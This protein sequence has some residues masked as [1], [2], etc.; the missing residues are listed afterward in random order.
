MQAWNAAS[1]W[2]ITLWRCGEPALVQFRSGAASLCV[3]GKISSH[4]YLS[5]AHYHYWCFCYYHCKT[6]YHTILYLYVS[7]GE[8]DILVMCANGYNEFVVLLLSCSRCMKSNF[9]FEINKLFWLTQELLQPSLQQEKQIRQSLASSWSYKPAG[10]ALGLDLVFSSRWAAAL[11]PTG[12]F[13]LKTR[14]AELH[15][16]LLCFCDR[17]SAAH[18]GICIKVWNW[19]D[20]K[21]KN[22]MEALRSDWSW[23]SDGKFTVALHC[24]TAAAF[25]PSH[26]CDDWL[27]VCAAALS[28]QRPPTSSTVFIKYT[29]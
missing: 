12:F 9:P 11:V 2:V 10:N 14:L 6:L 3:N 21:F 5:D 24:S 28:S 18:A 7:A 19:T 23:F 25:G 4:S 27:A 26:W 22:G 13:D 15:L 20:T 16:N 8:W 17:L 1:L 29:T